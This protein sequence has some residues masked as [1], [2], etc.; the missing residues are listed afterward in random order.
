VKPGRLREFGRQA[1]VFALAAVSAA[2]QP[3]APVGYEVASIKRAH[4]TDPR[5]HGIEFLPGGRFR[6]TGM[7]LLPVLATAYNIPWQSIESIRL[8][9]QNAPNWIFTDLYDIEA[10]AVGPGEATTSK[11]RN[12]RIR[13]KIRLSTT[14]PRRCR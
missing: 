4:G 10:K 8:R 3:A 12:E 13:M 6:S 9:I 1:A 7:P 14:R 11:A 2:A 5:A